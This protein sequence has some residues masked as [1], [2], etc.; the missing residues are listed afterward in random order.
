MQLRRSLPDDAGEIGALDAAAIH[1][2][3]AESWPLVRDADELHDA[4]L[5]LIAVPATDAWRDR[6]DVLAADRRAATI[7]VAGRPLWVAAERVHMARALYPAGVWD[8]DLPDVPQ[9]AFDGREAAV[10]EALRGW[11]ESSGPL[12]V[13]R[14]A[15]T[16]ALSREDIKIGLAPAGG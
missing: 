15:S 7:L 1:Q 16:L 12:T 10:A 2:V 11:L 6:H 14:L 9:R 4:L 3:A 5:T 13:S 8:R